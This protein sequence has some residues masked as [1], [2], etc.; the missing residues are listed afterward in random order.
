MWLT[1]YIFRVWQIQILNNKG[2]QISDKEDLARSWSRSYKDMAQGPCRVLILK[3]T[4][5][6]QSYRKYI[7]HLIYPKKMQYRFAVNFGTLCNLEISTH[8]LHD[9]GYLIFK[10]HLF[11]SR[12]ASNLKVLSP[13]NVFFLLHVHNIF[14]V[15]MCPSLGLKHNIN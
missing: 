5:C 11:R 8:V 13:K 9:L 10:G 2:R 14:L 3:S 4:E 1:Q 6:P 7:L 15:T 12:I